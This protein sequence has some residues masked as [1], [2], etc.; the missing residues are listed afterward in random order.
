M[1]IRQTFYELGLNRLR[2]LYAELATGINI[3][4]LYKNTLFGDSRDPKKIF[5]NTTQTNLF[6]SVSPYFHYSIIR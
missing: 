5:Q 3:D 6:T 4:I 2:F 1:N